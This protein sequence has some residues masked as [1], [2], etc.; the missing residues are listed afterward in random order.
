MLRVCMYEEH[1]VAIGFAS[2]L[3]GYQGVWS[4]LCRPFEHVFW[5][6]N[7]SIR[8]LLSLPSVSWWP[9]QLCS[10]WAVGREHLQLGIGR[11]DGGIHV[12]AHR[13]K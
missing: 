2:V 12:L 11:G 1:Q 7:G 3:T 8:L 10:G 9:A 13:P 5:A 6:S 4:L